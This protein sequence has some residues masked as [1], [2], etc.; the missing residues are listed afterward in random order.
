MSNSLIAFYT[1]LAAFLVSITRYFN[2][3]TVKMNVLY[4]IK[5]IVA[6]DYKQYY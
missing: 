4:L 5:N 6:T 2:D 1:T 3:L